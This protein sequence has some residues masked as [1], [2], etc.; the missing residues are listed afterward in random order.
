MAKRPR[1]ISRRRALQGAGALAALPSRVFAR[2]AAAARPRLM[3][4]VQSGD[5]GGDGATLWSRADRPARM[6]VEYATTEGF[7]DARRIEGPL[8][9]EPTGFTSRLRLA[10]LPP[11]QTIFYRIAYA[12]PAVTSVTSDWLQGRFRTPARVPADLSFVWSADTVGQGWGIN[13]DIGGMTIYETMRSLA[14]D[15][16]VHCGDTIYA[17]DPL[18]SEKRLPDGRIWKNLT[19]EAKSKVAETL[20]DFRGNHLY[21]FLDA[22]LRRFNAEVPMIALWDDHDVV[23]NWYR[24]K[25]LDTDPRYREKDVGLLARYAERAFREFMPLSDGLDGPMRLYRKFSFGPPLDLFRLD[26][27]SFRAPN[28]PNRQE[29]ARKD[30]AFL[31]LEQVDWL[32]QALKSSTATWKIIAADMPLGLVVYDDW[33]R[34][35]G[36]EAVANADDGPPRGR[37]LEIAG[38]LSF[39]KRENISNVHWIT[40]DVHYPATHRYDP[41]RA[42]FQDFTP[43]YEFVSGPLCAGGFGPNALDG[44]FGPEVVFQKV[45]PPG[46]FDLSPLEGSCHFGHVRIDGK[47]GVMTVSHRDAGGNVIHS[48]ELV[49][50]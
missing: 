35:S 23:D 36:F 2:T 32:K 22:N 29:V 34:K 6:I 47:S 39:I 33:R 44:T 3:Q 17:D 49:P 8:A 12:D 26:M 50:K 20:A 25:R 48:L 5:V 31:G 42:A 37:E 15:F 28:G 40:A 21:N 4:G 13:P 11:G 27:R 9:L 14:P 30:T 45:P 16:F 1:P 38:L 18:F 19:T 10:D 43:F 7:T 41:A 24:E 46:R